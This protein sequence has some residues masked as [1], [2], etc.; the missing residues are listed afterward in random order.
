M[1]LNAQCQ[2]V[3]CSRAS[4]DVWEHNDGTIHALC[5]E[6][7]KNHRQGYTDWEYDDDT[8]PSYLCEYCLNPI[9]LDADID[10]WVHYTHPHDDPHDVRP[11]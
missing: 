1:P 11:R 4:E 6:H 5:K 2:V 7:L 10:Q 8:S 9:Y 3:N